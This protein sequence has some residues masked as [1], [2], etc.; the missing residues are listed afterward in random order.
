[1]ANRPVI[2]HEAVGSLQIRI[3]NIYSSL[4]Q[5]AIAAA[6]FALQQ[7][8]EKLRKKSQTSTKWQQLYQI[9]A[10]LRRKEWHKPKDVLRRKCNISFYLPS[11]I[12]EKRNN[13]TKTAFPERLYKINIIEKTIFQ[14][15]GE[16]VR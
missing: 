5:T 1:M 11:Y 14:R 6:I 13:E 4:V 15:C 10:R 8:Q 16:Y 9:Y 3:T 7:P 2:L 12:S